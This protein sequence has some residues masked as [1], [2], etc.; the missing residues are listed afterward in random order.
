[1]G[2]DRKQ[3]QNKRKGRERMNSHKILGRGLLLALAALA[4]GVVLRLAQMLFFYDY[5]TGFPTDGGLTAWAG[6]LVPLALAAAAG[7][8]FYGK[9]RRY[10]GYERGAMPAAGA[11]GLVSAAALVVAGVQMA[12]DYRV[13]LDTGLSR[14]ESVQQEMIHV[15][16][17][18]M[19]LVYGLVQ[20]VAAA[21]MLAGKDVFGK[22]RL[23]YVA[24]VLWGISNLIMVYVFYAKSPS[25]IENF[26]S[27][28]GAASLLFCLMY[29]CKLMARV[30]EPGSAKRLFIS[31]GFMAALELSYLLGNLLL[32]IQGRTYFGESPILYQA[33]EASTGA[34]AL[35]Y[36][37][38]VYRA[39]DW[40]NEPTEGQRRAQREA[41]EAEEAAGEN[42]EEQH[43]A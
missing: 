39:G 1:M 12:A 25:F 2:I 29:I 14:F 33:A 26:F 31:G 18:V 30:E 13:Y 5:D 36:L 43:G 3:S 8:L 19:C 41:E 27:V 38:S 37:L 23:A 10:G 28:V 32:Y 7:G 22:A 34:F 21:G 15:F 24:G 40:E 11:L 4:A 20:A 9:D 35:A 6:L 42:Q 16:F 17:M